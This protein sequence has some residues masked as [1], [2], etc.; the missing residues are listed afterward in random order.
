MKLF[1][2]F[3]KF[4]F[5]KLVG[6]ILFIAISTSTCKKTTPADDIST[7]HN[8]GTANV[9]VAGWRSY[10]PNNEVAVYWK[11][12]DMTDLTDGSKYITANSIVASGNDIYVGGNQFINNHSIAKYWKNGVI[13]N[14]TDT[15]KDSYINAAAISGNNIYFAG[16]ENDGNHKIAKY[17]KN[18]QGVNLTSGVND[19]KVLAITVSG[20]DVYAVG[21]ESNGTVE[22]AKYWENGTAV[23]LTD[24][25]KNTEAGSIAVSGNDIYILL[26]EYTQSDP[27]LFC[28]RAITGTATFMIWKNGSIIKTAGQNQAFSAITVSNNVLYS[29][30]SVGN[31]MGYF[32]N[33]TPF[34]LTNGNS[35]AQASGIAIWGTDVYVTGYEN[36][37]GHNV[38][39]YWKNGVPT[40]LTDGI[41]NAYALSIYLDEQ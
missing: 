2:R 6:I 16:Y 22:V 5:S 23:N 20:N 30:G 10:Y 13:A 7:V 41:N 14:L 11:N 15:S 33:E 12:G 18:G 37:S 21:W 8:T 28:G 35:D 31:G 38:P 26:T 4:N 27:C 32:K 24:G 29:A 9:Y 19:A 25:S 1:G 34:N 39:T 36:V 17:W 40:R 3:L